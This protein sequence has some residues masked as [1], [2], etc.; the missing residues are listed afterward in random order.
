MSS[1]RHRG[2]CGKKTGRRS[3][4]SR[5]RSEGGSRRRRLA[6]GRGG[7][8][9]SAA[10]WRGRSHW[11]SVIGR[12]SGKAKPEERMRRSARSMGSPAS[13]CDRS[14]VANGNSRPDFAPGARRA[15]GRRRGRRPVLKRQQLAS[16]AHPPDVLA[17]PDRRG[18]AERGVVCASA[19]GPA[20]IA[21]VSLL[22]RRPHSCA[23]GWVAGEVD[24]LG[25]HA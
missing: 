19:P 11:I 5:S 18:H 9:S 25:E 4:R 7:W 10:G 23:V 17:E 8:R 12:S 13:A 21:V 1:S 24:A 22:T 20:Q 3:N 6:T 16:C 14:W 2:R 15:S